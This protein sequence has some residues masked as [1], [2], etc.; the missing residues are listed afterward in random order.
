MTR[1]QAAAAT[2]TYNKR[3]ALLAE[4]AQVQAECMI[5]EPR[6]KKLAD[7]ADYTG[8]WTTANAQGDRM[9]DLHE[10]REAAIAD[11]VA[12]DATYQEADPTP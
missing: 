6:F 3:E 1:E 8:D 2:A 11:L 10:R 4:L 7:K 12:A 5:A 9:V